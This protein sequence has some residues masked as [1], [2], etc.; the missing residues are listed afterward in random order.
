M[1][2]PKNPAGK[3][4][5]RLTFPQ[6]AQFFLLITDGPFP[7]KI[8][9][10][11]DWCLLLYIFKSATDESRLIT[12]SRRMLA[13]HGRHLIPQACSRERVLLVQQLNDYRREG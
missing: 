2:N 3:S 9:H 13:P 10:D 6:K 1:G 12:V 4:N 7:G 5:D 8:L 11:P